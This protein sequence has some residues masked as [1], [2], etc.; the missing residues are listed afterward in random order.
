VTRASA[1][2]A[3][4]IASITTIGCPRA[5]LASDAVAAPS[6]PASPARLAPGRAAIGSA[7]IRGITIGPI[8]NALH[9]GVG[10]GT[11]ACGRAL[12]RARDLGATWVAFTP[13]G[14]MHS[15][16][17]FDV[18]LSFE[19]SFEEN[20]MAVGRAID[21]AH[22]RGLKVMLVPHLWLE[23]GGWRGEIE[24]FAPADTKNE[25]G[26]VD[27]RGRAT[28]DGMRAFS[29]RY[30]RFLLAWAD[31]AAA[32]D[33]ELLSVGVELRSWATSGR[34]TRELEQL[35]AQ[36]RRHF[37]G[38]LTY[39]ANW[40]DVD[41]VVVLGLLD[42]IGINAFYPLAERPGADAATLIE[43][44]RRVADRVRDLAARWGKPVIFTE[45][46]Y[47][48]R[49]DP[50]VR[51][52]E[53]PDGMTNVIVDEA[54][55]ADAYRG[56]LAGVLDE[57]SFSGFFVW[58]LFADPDDAS[59]EAAWGFP[60]AG[61]L[62]ELEVRDAFATR[63]ASESWSPEWMVLGRGAHGAPGVSWSYPAVAW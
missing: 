28:D 10:Y 59:Q 62:A 25:R 15:T 32:H 37:G 56:L 31:V 11:P 16:R 42:V 18:D 44:G 57:P 38:A 58:R 17:S 5:D 20:S 55:Q 4:A 40:D 2:S 50:A 61:K 43:G 49:I 26:E 47:T 23:A 33:V 41:D 51:P 48:T 14:R 46:G 7:P 19:A 12:D 21:Q 60:F 34:A 54:A 8:E 63:F 1:W 53:W 3:I 29:G 36:T 27:V 22:A 24:P 6:P 30:S 39:S 35:I 52:W 13:F 9:P 45:V